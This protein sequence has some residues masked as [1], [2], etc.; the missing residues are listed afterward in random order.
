MPTR[1]I[2]LQDDA[3]DM[4]IN[5]CLFSLGCKFPISGALH[6]T[7]LLASRSDAK[8]L[9]VRFR[10]DFALLTMPSFT[11]LILTTPLNPYYK[12]INKSVEWKLIMG[13]RGSIYF[14]NYSS[15]SPYQHCDIIMMFIFL[16]IS[17]PLEPD[18]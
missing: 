11:F 10:H 3:I 13:Q 8:I 16:W 12:C 18:L 17:F 15:L 1:S 6:R 4:R 7:C 14:Y 2:D 9:L 5:V